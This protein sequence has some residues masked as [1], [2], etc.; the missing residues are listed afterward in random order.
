VLVYGQHAPYL[1][2][3]YALEIHF[4]LNYQEMFM[5][6]MDLDHV[7]CFISEKSSAACKVMCHE[8][9]KM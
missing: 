6:W 8:G 4:F 7:R 1:K 3:H 9:S 5:S 2:A